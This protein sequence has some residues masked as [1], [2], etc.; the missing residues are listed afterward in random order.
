MIKSYIKFKYHFIFITSMLASFIFR[1]K[2]LFLIFLVLYLIVRFFARRKY[3][4]FRDDQMTSSG[5]VLSPTNGKIV[6]IEKDISHNLYG[7]HLT[8]VRIALGWFAESSILM[9]VNS[10]I[11]S[12]I[13][14]RGKSFFR[15]TDFNKLTESSDGK[16]IYLQF[17]LLN[18]PSM[19]IGL[20]LLKCRLGFWP[21]LI[22]LPG[23]IGNRRANIGH[24][25]FGGT[26]LL[27]LPEKYEILISPGDNLTAGETILAV[28]S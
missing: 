18:E 9:P 7:D 6:Q 16:G 27:Y 22:V 8:E 19:K 5:I 17:A 23:D 26:V 13:V 28:K 3:I 1:Q 25:L 21:A 4:Y 20:T 15:Y 10:E 11:K 14:K 12:L 2:Y 24:F